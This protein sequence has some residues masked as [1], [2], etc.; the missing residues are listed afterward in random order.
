LYFNDGRGPGLWW[1]RLLGTVFWDAVHNFGMVLDSLDYTI[2][3][4]MSLDCRDR[5]FIDNLWLRF[6]RRELLGHRQTILLLKGFILA[7]RN[8]KSTMTHG[9]WLGKAFELA[10]EFGKDWP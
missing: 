6:L 1:H 3:T 10:F 5:D 4:F 8:T 9:C 7:G 2:G